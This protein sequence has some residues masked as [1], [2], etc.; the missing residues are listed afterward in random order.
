MALDQSDSSS[1]TRRKSRGTR[2]ANWAHGSPAISWISAAQKIHGYSEREGDKIENKRDD[3]LGLNWVVCRHLVPEIRAHA[4]S[5]AAHVPVQGGSRPNQAAPKATTLRHLATRRQGI[6]QDSAQSW[7]NNT[8]NPRACDAT[9]REWS[10]SANFP[11]AAV[12]HETAGCGLRDCNHSD[13]V[14]NAPAPCR[15][16]C[17][18]PQIL[19]HR[20]L[21]PLPRRPRCRPCLSI[22]WTSS[23]EFRTNMCSQG[24]PEQL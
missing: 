23:P 1:A 2:N 17:R 10:R 7:T 15:M 4:V 13:D 9:S 6:K 21:Q 12:R 3:G 19:I 18:L 20:V 11:S 22:S 5:E 24:H 14:A 16:L 8:V